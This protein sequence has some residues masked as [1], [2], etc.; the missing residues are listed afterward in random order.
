MRA[1]LATVPGCDRALRAIQN[2]TRASSSVTS[3]VT[4]SASTPSTLARRDR[5]SILFSS[6]ALVATAFAPTARA[7]TNA[8]T[9]MEPEGELELGLQPP[10]RVRGC[11]REHNCV[12][13]SSRESD[14][15]ASPWTAPNTFRDAKDAANALVDATLESVE[16]SKLIMREDRAEGSFVGFSVPGKLGDDVVEFWVKNEPVSDRNWSGDEGNGP[17]VLYRSF[18]M[19]V[20]YVYPFMTPVSDLGEQSKR[21]R[22]IRESLGWQI[23]GCELVECFQ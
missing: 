5:R 7:Q 19:D 18:A 20:K 23:L 9:I 13:T 2:S 8:R 22:K 15:Y 6:A 4:S 14:K 16:N 12:S 21:L 10:G 1:Q 17:L 3:P 11:P